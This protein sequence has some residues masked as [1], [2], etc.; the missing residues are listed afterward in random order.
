KRELTAEIGVLLGGRA[1]EKIAFG[2][3][4]GGAQNDLLRATLI[5]REMVEKLGMSDEVG[6]ATH[7]HPEGDGLVRRRAAATT[8][9]RIEEAVE[10]LLKDEQV[11]VERLLT[12]RKAVLDDMAA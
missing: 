11:R 1:A 6:P 3:I 10:K 7:F 2:E 9:R 8:E 12:E 5:A 4:S